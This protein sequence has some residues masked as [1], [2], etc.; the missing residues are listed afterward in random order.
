M[1]KKKKSVSLVLIVAIIVI[2]AI[3]AGIF[4]FI[5][6]GNNE[7]KG[8]GKKEN[9]AVEKSSSEADTQGTE[10]VEESANTEEEQKNPE[11]ETITGTPQTDEQKALRI[12][13]E[14]WNASGVAFYVQGM[15]NNGNYIIAV[16]DE[17]TKVLA[18]YTVNINDGTFTKRENN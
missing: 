18:F 9:S 12:V 16:S 10:N 17:T 3:V 1:K 15:D 6:K 2:G 4:A 5:G 11:E 8:Q 13:E 7:A 14:D